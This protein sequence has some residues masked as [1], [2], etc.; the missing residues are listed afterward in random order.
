ML[1]ANFLPPARPRT[2]VLMP[3]RLSLAPLLALLLLLMPAAAHAQTLPE[4]RWTFSGPGYFVPEDV[5]ENS[6][7]VFFLAVTGGYGTGSGAYIYRSADGGRTWANTTNNLVTTAKPLGLNTMAIAAADGLVAAAVYITSS[8]TDLYVSTNNG[9]TWTRRSTLPSGYAHV[10]DLFAPDASTVVAYMNKGSSVAQ[11][12]VSR[13]G[14]ATWTVNPEAFAPVTAKNPVLAGGVLAIPH[15]RRVNNTNEPGLYFSTDLGATWT[16]RVPTTLSGL[17]T[18]LWADGDR[19]YYTGRNGQTL[20]IFLTTDGGMTF[21]SS[22]ST[23]LFAGLDVAG[24]IVSRGSTFVALGITPIVRNGSG[25]TVSGGETATSTSVDGGATWTLGDRDS[26]LLRSQHNANVP[27]AFNLTATRTGFL[28]APVLNGQGTRVYASTDGSG[29]DPVNISG[30]FRD[31]GNVVALGN[32]LLAFE[33]KVGGGDS[34]GF[35]RSND[36]GV[37][38]RY[39]STLSARPIAND[40]CAQTLANGL[41]ATVRTA[42]GDVVVAV[43]GGNTYHSTDG[44]TFMLIGANAVPTDRTKMLTEEAGSLYLMTWN[45]SMGGYGGQDA[46]LYRSDDLGLTWTQKATGLRTYTRPSVSGNKVALTDRA[47]ASFSTDGGATFT[48]TPDLYG[49]GFSDIVATPTAFFAGSGYERIFGS[50]YLNRKTFF[51]SRDGGAT[52]Q[53]LLAS[54]EATDGPRSLH[55]AAPWLVSVFTDSVAISNDDGATWRGLATGWPVGT[56]GEDAFV[57]GGK[58]YV[59]VLFQGLYVAPLS[60]FGT[61][62][63]AE[64]DARAPGAS[65]AAWPSPA[66]GPVT[67]R[68]SLGR[69]SHA[70]VAVYDLLGRTV[71]ALADGPM[72]AGEHTVRWNPDVLAAGRYLVRLSTPGGPSVTRAVVRW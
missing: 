6:Q 32:A 13:D 10:N 31:G 71:A 9:D 60:A 3:R 8:R 28:Y 66:H 61:P 69:A 23:S 11:F 57:H 26:T 35:F 68:F 53:D 59:Q 21:S 14:G 16:L 24:Q 43:C 15:S 70:R 19:I 40:G 45:V 44:L 4:A 5:A 63:A 72:E 18:F 56:M 38:W 51:R 29:W 50:T 2:S 39:L 65:L 27:T 17:N 58:L 41:A 48:H 42:T 49:S 55:Y 36:G 47:Q 54:G 22:S 20:S 46:V 37:S 33:D 30:F 64:Q 12:I 52:W 34:N 25:Q 1:N 62:V 7:Y 67:V